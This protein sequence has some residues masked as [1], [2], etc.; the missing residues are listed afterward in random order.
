MHLGRSLT[1]QPDCL[2]GWVVC[3]TVYGTCT[4]KDF[5]GS[6]SRVGYCIPVLDFY[7]VAHGLPSQKRQYN[8]F[9][10]IKNNKDTN[11]K[12]TGLLYFR[13][14]YE[15]GAILMEEE[16][17]VIGGMLVSL[18]IIDCNISIKDED[19]DQPVSNEQPQIH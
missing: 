9:I 3:G 13:D 2:K 17:I 5:L 4:L 6:I 19:L 7:P 15:P 16:S 18:N 8:G 14:Y 11:F 10:I 12:N 1:V